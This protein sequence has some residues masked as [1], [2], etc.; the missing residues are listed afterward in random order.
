MLNAGMKSYG[1]CTCFNIW[2]S[3]LDQLAGSKRRLVILYYGLQ[4]CI[5]I[6]HL[7]VSYWE[8]SRHLGIEDEIPRLFSS[9]V[10]A[11]VFLWG[12]QNSEQ[13]E[14][15]RNRFL[16]LLM[17]T[18]GYVVRNETST[19]TLKI[20]VSRRV[21]FLWTRILDMPNDRYPRGRTLLR[22]ILEGIGFGFAWTG[23]DANIVREPTFNI[24]EPLR[25]K[26][27]LEEILL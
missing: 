8:Q 19:E 10:T 5:G 16:G 26:T 20:E 1:W 6:L 15:V 23:Q 17:S 11:T 13:L 22:I 2:E 3:Y 12:L 4:A 14:S 24:L 25:D 27:I 18:P 9:I 21:P 7:E